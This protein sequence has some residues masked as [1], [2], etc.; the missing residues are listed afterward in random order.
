VAAEYP[1]RLL[2]GLI[3]SDGC[4]VLNR[5]NGK[6]Y[7]RYHFINFSEGIRRIYTDACDALGVSWTQPKKQEVS[8]ARAADVAIL[9]AL[10]PRKA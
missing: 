8:V 10:V 6:A 9:D 1:A 3:H 4:R 5:V 7:P 2:A